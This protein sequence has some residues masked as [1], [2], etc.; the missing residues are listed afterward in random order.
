MIPH[1][2]WVWLLVKQGVR[3]KQPPGPVYGTNADRW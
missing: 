1:A 2:A 3:P